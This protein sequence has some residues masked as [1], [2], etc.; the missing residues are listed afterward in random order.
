[1][2]QVTTKGNEV[3]WATKYHTDLVKSQATPWNSATN[4]ISSFDMIL[5]QVQWTHVSK[6]LKIT[7]RKT[8]VNGQETVHHSVGFW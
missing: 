5:A 8:E 3:Q 1:M 7:D 2:K 6:N 4:C